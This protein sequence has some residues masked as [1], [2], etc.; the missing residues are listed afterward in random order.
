MAVSFE[1]KYEPST[2]KKRGTDQFSK[3]IL[4]HRVKLPV[5]CLVTYMN[6]LLTI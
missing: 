6:F 5:L 4:H 2:S 1:H 3:E